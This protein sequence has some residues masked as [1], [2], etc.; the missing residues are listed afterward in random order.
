MGKRR[1]P[2]WG[3]ESERYAPSRSVKQR[4]TPRAEEDLGGK[5]D[6]ETS[7]GIENGVELA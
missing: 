1:S 3:R 2:G 7:N 5:L 6:G 4:R